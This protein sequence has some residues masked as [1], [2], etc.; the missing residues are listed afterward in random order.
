MDVVPDASVSSSHV[1][2]R[3]TFASFRLRD[4]RPEQ[5][6]GREEDVRM[7]EINW[8]GLRRLA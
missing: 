7:G 1:P 2:S 5:V 6:L 4:G 3:A 8:E